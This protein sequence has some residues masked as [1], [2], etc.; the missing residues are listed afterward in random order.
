[1]WLLGSAS[2]FHATHKREWSSSYE[3]GDFGKAY[4]GDH[5]GQP[6]IGIGEIKIKMEGRAEQVLRG[7]KHVPEIR[8]NLISLGALNHD[9]F[10]FR[11]EPDGRTMKIMKGDDAMMIGERMTSNLYKLQGCVVAGGV[12]ED[13]VAGI[14]EFSSGGESK[15]LDS[16]GGSL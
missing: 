6:V 2:S 12:I 13:G 1:M 4:L 3:S 10:L 15:V 11:A 16:S 14:A 7:V 5:R 9:G 8:R